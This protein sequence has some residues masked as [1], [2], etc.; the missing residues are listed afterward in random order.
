ME[1]RKE[2]PHADFAAPYTV[3]NI[4][5]NK[6]RLSVEINYESQMI[7]IRLIETHEEYSRRLKR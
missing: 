7:F 5:G 4:G 6:Y 3:F 2:Y 1:V